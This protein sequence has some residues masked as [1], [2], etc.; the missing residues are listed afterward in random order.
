MMKTARLGISLVF[1]F[2][3]VTFLFSCSQPPPPTE[4]IKY[5]CTIHPQISEMTD[6][7]V[8]LDITPTVIPIDEINN[9]RFFY[10]IFDNS[11]SYADMIEI[12]VNDFVLAMERNFHVGDEVIIA[13]LGGRSSGQ[14]SSYIIDDEKIRRLP[15]PERIKT[16]PT[17]IDNLSIPTPSV[18]CER[19][20]TPTPLPAL[21]PVT[22][23]YTAWV[24]EATKVAQ[25][26]KNAE[27]REQRLREKRYS[28]VK[29]NALCKALHEI[30]EY[31]SEALKYKI[32]QE[33][34]VVTKKRLWAFNL[35]KWL[36]NN[37]PTKH[38]NICDALKPAVK[39]VMSKRDS[40]NFQQVKL[41][42]FSDGIHNFTNKQC[43]AFDDLDAE[44]LRGIDV[45]FLHVPLRNNRYSSTEDI[46]RSLTEWESKFTSFGASFA[47]FI[48]PEGK[49]LDEVMR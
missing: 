21:T 18:N 11:G 36:S 2:F 12:A 45:Y 31:N 4:E 48:Y 3:I 49:D 1:I 23:R 8:Q 17:N 15:L 25:F 47:Y 33:N 39:I 26:N 27:K 32:Q 19:K 30:E 5:K 22:S 9:Q 29:R 24:R 46:N 42:I 14:I 10:V 38:T 35:H 43:G 13:E 6:C 41:L 7:R 44:S 37:H 20:N 16:P 40:N 28:L 34:E